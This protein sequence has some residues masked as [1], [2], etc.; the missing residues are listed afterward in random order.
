MTL[1]Q[2]P[3]HDD[4]STGD[5]LPAA[6]ALERNR[7]ALLLKSYLESAKPADDGAIRPSG[8]HSR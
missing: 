6:A 1:P 4:L 8:H 5:P 7:I 2:L 3:N